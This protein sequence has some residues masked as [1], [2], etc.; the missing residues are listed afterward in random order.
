MSKSSQVN[1]ECLLANREIFGTY[2]IKGEEVTTEEMKKKTEKEREEK[3][4]KTNTQSLEK[5]EVE[6][7]EAE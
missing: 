7:V 3:L 4:Q 2:R 6:Q 1:E 5:K